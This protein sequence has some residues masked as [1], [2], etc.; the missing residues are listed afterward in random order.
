MQR[1]LINASVATERGESAE[2]LENIMQSTLALHKRRAS[3]VLSSL[4][5]SFENI[6]DHPS[7]ALLQ[8]F[9]NVG[10]SSGRV[11]QEYTQ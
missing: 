11:E 6:P 4:K 8:T 2:P 1:F 3:G 9:V 10:N 7:H 5:S